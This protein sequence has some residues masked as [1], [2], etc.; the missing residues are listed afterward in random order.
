MGRLLF[1]GASFKSRLTLKWTGQAK[2]FLLLR[3]IS[4]VLYMFRS[5]IHSIISTGNQ[6]NS[7]VTMLR[8]RRSGSPASFF[9]T[10]R[11]EQF[12][13]EF[14]GENIS[15]EKPW[16][17]SIYD[18]FPVGRFCSILLCNGLGF[19]FFSAVKRVTLPLATS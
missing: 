3:T 15:T 7:L 16:G 4:C 6:L 9:R 13:V 14:P 10:Q 12:P 11:E 17:T 2:G 1:G 8:V 5:T 18:G 19:D